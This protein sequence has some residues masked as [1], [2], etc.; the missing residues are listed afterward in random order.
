M[1]MDFSHGMVA[2]GCWR[3]INTPQRSANSSHRRMAV[4]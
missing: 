3:L 1:R 2:T 4:P